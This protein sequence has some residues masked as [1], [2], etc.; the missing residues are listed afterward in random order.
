MDWRHPANMQCSAPPSSFHRRRMYCTCKA[1][2]YRITSLLF[3]LYWTDQMPGR[4]V[5][6]S[7]WNIDSK[8]SLMNLAMPTRYFF[9]MDSCTVSGPE[10]EPAHLSRPFGNLRH[11]NFRCFSSPIVL[12][13]HSLHTLSSLGTFGFDQE[14]LPRAGYDNPCGT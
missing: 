2:Q 6:A 8:H 11:S 10:N 9:Q 3:Q 12:G 5:W 7:S 13:E 1:R 4:H 14:P